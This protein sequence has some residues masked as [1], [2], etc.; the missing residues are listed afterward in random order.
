MDLAEYEKLNPRC[1]VRCDERVDFKHDPMQ[2]ACS[3]GC[4]SASLDERVA[5]GTVA[6]PDFLKIDV[7]GFEPKVIRGAQN[8]LR[9]GAVRSLLIEINQNLP[10]H[11]AL[12]DE[13]AGW[14]FRYDRAQV[15][16]AERKSGDFKGCA[17]YVFV[18]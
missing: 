5:A 3:Q 2:P 9:S 1:T 18:R 10:D 17:D 14:G 12:V 16:R 11:M 6:R 4:V 13:L 15:A 8:T 7:D